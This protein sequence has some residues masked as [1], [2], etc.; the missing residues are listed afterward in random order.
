MVLDIF[1][2]KGKKNSLGKKDTT[3]NKINEIKIG[4]KKQT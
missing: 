4:H 2:M 1:F 3:K